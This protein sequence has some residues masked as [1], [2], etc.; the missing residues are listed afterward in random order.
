MKVKKQQLP[1]L[2]RKEPEWNPV[3]FQNVWR[4]R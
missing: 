2:Y 4:T 3:E 1:Y